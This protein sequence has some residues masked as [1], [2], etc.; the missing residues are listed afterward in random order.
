MSAASDGQAFGAP[1]IEPRW[2]RSSKE[3]IGTAYHTSC[4]VWFTLSHGIINEI[5][6]PNVDCPNTRDLQFLL[7]DGE[8]FCHEERRD[9]EHQIEYPE[10]GTPYYRLINRDPQGRYQLV[11]DVITDPHSSVFLMKTRVEIFDVALRSKLKLYALLAPHMK[12]LGQNN[13]AWWYDVDCRPVFRVEREHQ[14]M[15]FGALPDFT[16]RSVGYVGFSDGWQDLMQHFKMEWEFPQAER[17]N[18]AL[19]AELTLS[20]SQ[21][22]VLGVAFGHSSQSASSKLLQSLAIPFEQHLEHYI[23]QWKRTVPSRGAPAEMHEASGDP[24]MLSPAVAA[25]LGEPEDG[26]RLYRLSRVLLLA[27]ED[28]VYPGALVASMSIP[29]GETKSDADL[30]GYH[31]VWTRDLVKSASAL[32]AAGQTSTPLRSLIW[33]ASIQASDGSVPQ[34]SWING[35]AYWGG[36]QLD[37]VAAPI[38][39]AWRLRDQKALA[40]FDPWILVLRAA[41]YLVLHGPVTGQERWEEN[42]GYSPS[43]L[44]WII[45]GLVCAA[46]FAQHRAGE[47]A[48]TFLLEYADWLVSHLEDWMVTNCGELVAGHPRH[49]IRIA[50]ADPDNPQQTAEPNTAMIDVGNGGGRHPARNVVSTDFLELVRLGVR[51]A[52]DPAVLE[53]IVVIDKVL[54]RDLPQ[55][56]CWHRYNHDGYGEGA[57]GRAFD[58][59]GIGRC[60]PLLTGERG[61]YELAAGRDPS[62]YLQAMENFANEGWMLPEQVW[63]EEDLPEAKMFRGR[64]TGSAMPLCWAHAEYVTLMRSRHDRVGFDCLPPVRKRY[65]ADRVQSQIEIWTLAHQP[66]RIEPGKRLRLITAAPVMVHWS[67]DDWR[68]TRDDACTHTALGLWHTDLPT[69][70][71]AAGSRIVFTFRWQDPDRWEGKNYGV[72]I[73]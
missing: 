28:K 6:Y 36:R 42:S 73:G 67:A 11:K 41:R 38:L 55:G 3:G 16:R 25:T 18:I 45:A 5:Y 10:K 31:L 56:P 33:L 63:D 29:W 40:L 34:N 9:L 22:V 61:H 46:D 32:L 70:E 27:H 64:P 71:M 8:T 48:A 39:L 44:A 58:G 21:E 66:P 13:S 23:R 37:E 65:A 50:P 1:G 52:D 14:H 4:R 60:W 15:V 17:G 57:D 20:D 51:R 59:A 47:P 68:T 49:Y 43:T 19:T 62:P 12:G 30:G 54:K 26:G 53:T 35:A 69:A 72:A 2:T 7:S 24:K